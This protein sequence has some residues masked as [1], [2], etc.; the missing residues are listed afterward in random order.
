MKKNWLTVEVLKLLT[1]Y[2]TLR[3]SVSN[4]SVKVAIDKNITDIW[5][6]AKLVLT[7]DR[8]SRKLQR[9]YEWLR[10]SEWNKR[11]TKSK[12]VAEEMVKPFD[13]QTAAERVWFVVTKL[14]AE[15]EKTLF[16]KLINFIW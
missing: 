11:Q 14:Q 9:E 10:G 4:L 7:I 5:Q 1:E 15:K 13:F 3:D 8:L 2:P 12:E 6:F 16:S